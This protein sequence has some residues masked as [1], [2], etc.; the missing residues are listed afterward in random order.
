MTMLRKALQALRAT[1]N[2]PTITISIHYATLCQD[3][4]YVFYRQSQTRPPDPEG[5]PPPIPP[6]PQVLDYPKSSERI[7]GTVTV[8]NTSGRGFVCD[9]LALALFSGQG[10]QPPGK[11]QAAEGKK[12]DPRG[13][14]KRSFR[15]VEVVLWNDV[16]ELEP[17][18]HDFD[19]SVS[20]PEQLPSTYRTF[21]PEDAILDVTHMFIATLAPEQ[22]MGLPSLIQEQE[23]I[24]M[25]CNGWVTPGRKTTE[26]VAKEGGWQLKVSYPDPIFVQY[27]SYDVSLS[28][29]QID[30][31][32]TILKAVECGWAERAIFQHGAYERP[33]GLPM[34]FYD[35]DSLIATDDEPLTFTF[36]VMQLTSD[37]SHQRATVS[38]EL[39]FH[40]EHEEGGASFAVPVRVLHV[41]PGTEEV[42]DEE[43]SPKI[44]EVKGRIV[45]DERPKAIAPAS[46]Q[47]PTPSPSPAPVVR[48]KPVP[49]HEPTPEPPRLPTPEP[50]RARTPSPP[51]RVP[52]PDPVPQ[53]TSA[54]RPSPAASLDNLMDNVPALESP[55][56]VPETA[57]SP[58]SPD[59]FG[60]TTS[61]GPPS[62]AFGT[63]REAADDALQSNLSTQKP[64]ETP[65]LISLA[66]EEVGTG[67]NALA[68]DPF[69]LGKAPA[70]HMSRQDMLADLMNAPEFAQQQ[71]E[72]ASRRSIESQRHRSAG[73]ESIPIPAGNR[74][75]SGSNVSMSSRGPVSPRGNAPFLNSEAMRSNGSVTIAEEDEAW[76]AEGRREGVANDGSPGLERRDGEPAVPEPVLAQSP[77]KQSKPAGGQSLV[78]A[79]R[80]KFE[81]E[82]KA[83]EKAEKE[84]EERKEAEKQ[85]RLAKPGQMPLEKHRMSLDTVLD[86]DRD[87]SD[88]FKF[89]VAG[90][91][92]STPDFG[93]G[94]GASEVRR[95]GRQR[96][97]SSPAPS[98]YRDDGE[99]ARGH[100][101][102]RSSSF[103]V[104]RSDA[105]PVPR[106]F[107]LGVVA[108]P[109]RSTA[110]SPGRDDLSPR[111]PHSPYLSTSP[112]NPMSPTRASPS[113]P[114]MLSRSP[115]SATVAASS[116]P[117]SITRR[118]PVPPRLVDIS[119]DEEDSRHRATVLTSS[120][121]AS[122]TIHIKEDSASPTTMTHQRRHDDDE[123]LSFLDDAE[124]ML[125]DAVRMLGP[126]SKK[127]SE[128]PI[129]NSFEEKDKK[130]E[131]DQWKPKRKMDLSAAN[132]RSSILVNEE[133]EREMIDEALAILNKHSGGKV[134][135]VKDD[136]DDEGDWD[137]FAMLDEAVKMLKRQS[138][139]S[140]E[141][142]KMLSDAM[143]MLKRTSGD[144]SGIASATSTPNRN[145]RTS[146]TPTVVEPEER[147]GDGLEVVDSF[148][149]RP[150]RKS[151]FMPFDNN[152]ASEGNKMD[153][154]IV[155]EVE[156]ENGEFVA[157]DGA[158]GEGK[159]VSWEVFA[160]HI[161][162]MEDE[163]DLDIG[164]YVTII[165]VFADNWAKGSN[166]ATGQIGM[167]P[168]ALLNPDSDAVSANST[169]SPTQP[170]PPQLRPSAPIPPTP[171]PTTQEERDRAFKRKSHRRESIYGIPSTSPSRFLNNDSGP[172]PVP[173]RRTKV[174]RPMPPAPPR[175]FMSREAAKVAGAELPNRR[176]SVVLNGGNN[177]NGVFGFGKLWGREKEKGKV[178]VS[179][180]DTFRVI[181]NFE[182][183]GSD[184]IGVRVGDVVSVSFTYKDG[185]CRGTNVATGKQGVFPKAC[186]QLDTNTPQH[187]LTPQPKV[188]FIT[189]PTMP[190]NNEGAMRGRVLSDPP[191]P[192]PS[193][194]G[195][196]DGHDEGRSMTLDRARKGGMGGMNAIGRSRTV[197]HRGDEGRMQPIQM[198]MPEIHRRSP[199]D[200]T[201]E[202]MQTVE[203]NLQ[204]SQIQESLR[205]E[206][207]K[208]GP[209]ARQLRLEAVAESAGLRRAKSQRDA[210]GRA[211]AQYEDVQRMHLAEARDGIQDEWDRRQEE[212]ES[213]QKEVERRVRMEME[214]R[215]VG[216]RWDGGNSA[217]SGISNASNRSGKSGSQGS[218]G[219]SGGASGLGREM[220]RSGYGLY[221]HM[222]PDMDVTS[223]SLPRPPPPRT[224]TSALRNDTRDR[225]NTIGTTDGHANYPQSRPMHPTPPQRTITL[226]RKPVTNPPPMPPIP[227][228]Q[229]PPPIIIPTR[230]G[231]DR[232]NTMGATA[233][234]PSTHRNYVP[235]SQQSHT[236]QRPKKEQY[237][238][239]EASLDRAISRDRSNPKAPHQTPEFPHPHQHNPNHQT[240]EETFENPARF[241]DLSTAI[242]NFE[243]FL[244]KAF[245]DPSSSSS[246][247]PH[248]HSHVHS[249]SHQNQ[250]PQA[251]PHRKAP[252]IT[253]S[254]VSTAASSST[255]SPGMDHDAAMKELDALYIAS[256]GGGDNYANRQHDANQY[257]NWYGG[258]GGG[259]G[260]NATYG[261]AEKEKKRL[262]PKFGGFGSKWK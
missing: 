97:E 63:P 218:S 139:R 241:S 73:Q 3:E 238:D 141:E 62:P 118:K 106:L 42:E 95:L 207:E 243:A 109:P 84:E 11:N 166:A 96:N 259:G 260:G 221:P 186:L 108:T 59:A 223:R 142:E 76:L 234:L 192:D 101:R 248:S 153:D 167:F 176:D 81:A 27:P 188:P 13:S 123:D 80:A 171:Q 114:S 165:Q 50:P 137:D 143:K 61:Y 83:R 148:K 213:R 9:R 36:P 150:S 132:A 168:L 10:W 35:A 229:P 122:S 215:D 16:R 261:K 31:N 161:P 193:V 14:H 120:T 130:D 99:F 180:E 89:G 152:R 195:P 249:H 135:D 29:E 58:N 155:E 158:G 119:D 44:E 225:S 43:E 78:Q 45:M 23:L 228:H 85:D 149:T 177:A 151:V 34:R 70:A 21:T 201:T 237:D 20:F 240:Q 245:D 255:S 98:P 126:G 185:W 164:D 194:F 232:S 125:A 67:K 254:N 12:P 33:L 179:N 205:P 40:I 226:T 107:G 116:P 236:L 24:V 41:P 17:G 15:R 127:S 252:N 156:N 115:A 68:H 136:D 22:S 8:N 117:T 79:M 113:L 72:D 49:P 196:Y 147:K 140:I 93:R 159:V 163:L 134:D 183:R 18:S 257:G 48:R 206:P 189:T 65:L 138:V 217:V 222:T 112:K 25:R 77:P 202:I 250:H 197:A 39:R 2:L 75:R 104:E 103:G 47:E 256:A 162:E 52:S 87:A 53:I 4:A 160:E 210:R 247:S 56:L 227:H 28:V 242:N 157:M 131:W 212:M 91:A 86:D 246:S 231:R 100:R 239:Y 173:T 181:R 57:R 90:A 146:Y 69:D 154:I 170:T 182:G 214:K 203:R 5:N 220:E 133:R 60:R 208:Y 184:E 262:L 102:G 32:F 82:R 92:A 94:G 233:Q 219:G 172:P 7:F 129:A 74:S 144:K 224:L 30:G 253:K 244:S 6:I 235:D 230:T 174:K 105:N 37:S 251:Q 26:C 190:A 198:D 175:Q 216:H 51:P 110:S 204:L 19:F 121:S 66:D 145:K 191:V 258:G 209:N 169:P 1:N 64:P 71:Q 128:P 46:V 88:K 199:Q 111:S 55:V 187:T 200:L 124:G 38:H 178:G 211:N 54:S